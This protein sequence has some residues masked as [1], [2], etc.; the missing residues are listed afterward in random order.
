M[1]SVLYDGCDPAE[2][3]FPDMCHRADLLSSMAKGLA[4]RRL[5]RHMRDKQKKE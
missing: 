5:S 3:G 2:P 4:F 1:G